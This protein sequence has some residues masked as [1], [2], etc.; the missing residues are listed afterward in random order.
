M[1]RHHLIG[2]LLAASCSG[3]P[4]KAPEGDSTA[5]SPE[6]ST[7]AVVT[8]D[9][10]SLGG[11]SAAASD[12]FP[13]VAPPPQLLSTDSLRPYLVFIPT[14]ER[15][16]VAA[17]RGKRMLLD[18]GRV[19]LEV[20]KDSTMAAAYRAAVERFSPIRIGDSLF[21]RAPWG[22]EWVRTTGVE[23]WN[24]RIALRLA[25]SA[26]MDSIAAEKAPVTASAERPLGSARSSTAPSSC[27]RTPPSPE[28]AARLKQLRDSLEARLRADGLPLYPRLQKGITLSSSQV[29]GCFSGATAILAVSLR[30]RGNEWVRERVVAVDADG[31]ATPLTVRDLRFRVHDLL[32]AVDI[33]GD[34]LDDVAAVGR[35][36]QAGGTVVLKFEAKE[37]RLTRVAAGF[38]WES[39]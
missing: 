24:G 35:T 1:R 16:F 30:A 12:T 15:W 27:Q 5:L 33:D 28:L 31:R 34:G 20:R 25:G 7:S 18:I 14:G 11:D 19:D 13:A 38:N 17:S 2:L 6:D 23:S 8:S 22:S 29:T 4:S 10:P 9:A 37:R 39:L 3:D 26:L 36:H 21:L 32:H